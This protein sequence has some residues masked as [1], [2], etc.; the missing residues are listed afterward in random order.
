MQQMNKRRHKELDFLCYMTI[1]I[2][3]EPLKIT[4]EGSMA[5]DLDLLS[6]F[7]SPQ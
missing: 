4:P 2:A 1:E 3:G 5:L 7:V 6:F